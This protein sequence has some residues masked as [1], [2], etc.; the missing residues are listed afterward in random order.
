MSLSLRRLLLRASVVHCVGMYPAYICIFLHEHVY[1]NITIAAYSVQDG[2]S[3]LAFSKAKVAPM[4][5]KSLPTLELLAV[6]LSF[7]CLLPLLKAYS[8]IRI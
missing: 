8:R 1:D 2:E 6:F 7:K 5:P 3:H 4:K